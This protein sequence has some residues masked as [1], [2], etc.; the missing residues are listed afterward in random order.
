MYGLVVNKYASYK[1]IKYEL[2]IDD[3]L[4]LLEIMIVK[5]SNTVKA[6]KSKEK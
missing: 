1:E 4:A 3:I 6:M 5:E 2:E